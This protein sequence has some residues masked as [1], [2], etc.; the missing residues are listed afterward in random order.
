M[1]KEKFTGVTVVAAGTTTGQIII[2]SGLSRFV[3]WRSS[4]PKSHTG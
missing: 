3:V 1:E 4:G 2:V